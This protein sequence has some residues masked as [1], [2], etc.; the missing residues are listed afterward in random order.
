MS[1]EQY[2]INLIRTKSKGRKLALR[3]KNEKIENMLAENGLYADIYISESLNRIQNDENT[4]SSNFLD[5]KS[6]EY[7]IIVPDYA[8]NIADVERYKKIGFHDIEDILWINHFPSII[9]GKESDIYGNV[10]ENYTETPIKFR[11]FGASTYIGK[12]VKLP[13]NGLSL[14]SDCHV[15]IGNNTDISAWW[16]SL[17]GSNELKI[18]TNVWGDCPKTQII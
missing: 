10:C 1:S 9:K 14:K 15:H 12:N 17:A 2:I 5:G 13:K 18:G 4:Y 3:W 11:G 8:Q 16:I 7:Y 6:Q